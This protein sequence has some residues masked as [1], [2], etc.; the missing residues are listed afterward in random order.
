MKN[1]FLR[2]KDGIYRLK[3]PFDD[4]YTSV[5]LAVTPKRLVLVDC[6][7]TADDVKTYIIPALKKMGYMLCDVDV[8]VLTHRHDDHAGGLDCVL[9]HAPD[10]EI[11]TDEHEL[12]DGV[13][14]YELYGHT[15]DCIGVLDT[16]TRTL[17]SGDGIQGMGVGK[18]RCFLENRAAYLQTL[19][20]IKG[21]GRIE[22]I[23]FSHAYE[24]WN[25]DRAQGRE[26]VLECINF[27]TEYNR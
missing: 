21:D 20:R 19:E 16:R 24:P 13:Y 4:L 8:L 14:T 10:I 11:I 25:S 17:I 18:Y 7:T 2:E 26:A 3:V 22:N 9:R 12:A 27:C 5:F 15:R 6:A 23:L 1:E